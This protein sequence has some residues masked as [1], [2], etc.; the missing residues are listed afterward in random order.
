MTIPVFS[1]RARTLT[2]A[3]A[4]LLAGVAGLSSCNG[5]SET[6]TS[7]PAAKVESS[8]KDKAKNVTPMTPLRITT[9]GKLSKVEVSV[10][11]KP[12]KL[13]G[14]I[15]QTGTWVNSEPLSLDTEYVVRATA[16]NAAGESTEIEQTFST[17]TPK[18]DATYTVTPDGSTVG[19]GM[20]VVVRFDSPVETDAQR[21]EVEKRVSV[22]TSTKTKGAWGWT[23]QFTLMWRPMSYWKPKT[24]VSVNADLEGVQTGSGKW[25]RKSK[26]AAFTIA[27]RARVVKVNLSDHNMK[28][29][30]NGKVIAQYPISAG[31][32]I[33]SW[34]TRSGTKVITELHESLVMDAGTLGVGANDPNYYKTEVKYAV[35]VTNTG[36]FFHSAPWSVS[37]QGYRNVSHGCVNMSPGAAREFFNSTIIGDPAEFVGS[38]RKMSP[39]DGMPV[40]LYTWKEWKQLS[41]LAPA[42]PTPTASSSTTPGQ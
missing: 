11:D 15:D 26:K 32:E 17:V 9:D 24:K 25:I 2:W 37:A 27:N 1:A 18:V 33:G 5:G 23:D 3:A 10:K 16:V 35:R 39:E 28:V 8:V 14:A 29:V 13:S 19:V 12:G 22:R 20:P 38:S 36:E 40:W 7:A 41:A 21:A 34:E 30:E 42:E 31:R 4:V 6:T